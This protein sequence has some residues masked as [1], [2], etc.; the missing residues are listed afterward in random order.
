M[1]QETQGNNYRDLILLISIALSITSFSFVYILN[2]KVKQQDEMITKLTNLN[3]NTVNTIA[4]I[5]E[6]LKSK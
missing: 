6:L 1:T 5:V 3:G 2:Y 4:N